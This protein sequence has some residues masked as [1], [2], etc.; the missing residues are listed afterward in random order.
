MESLDIL[1]ENK[2]NGFDKV[3]WQAPTNIAFVKYWGKRDNQLPQNPSI[4]LT[5]ENSFTDT[6]IYYRKSDHTLGSNVSFYFDGKKNLHFEE[7][8]RKYLNSIKEF[9]PFISDY[10]LVISSYNTFPHSA[11]IASSASSMAS[12]ALCLTAMEKKL[13]DELFYINDFYKK[14]SY[15]ARLGSGSASRSIYGSFTV[16]GQHKDIVDS[17]DDYAVSIG[18]DYHESF[19]YLHDSIL[20]VN[21]KHKKV[22]SS[23]GHSLMNAHPFAEKRYTLANENLSK[24]YYAIKEGNIDL[25]IGIIESEALTLHSLM[26]TSN[27]GYI[28]IEPNTIKIINKIREIRN[29]LKLP[30][31]FTL[32]AGPNVHLIYQNKYKSEVHDIIKNE[33]MQYCMHHKWIDDYMGN[34]P[35]EIF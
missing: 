23:L 34:G 25:F 24:I 31:G 35:K 10:E 16:W 22:S 5:L 8:I 28:L 2:L 15:I 27:P 9:F 7:R 32:D 30:I 18:N 33:L 1:N 3:R 26:M 20:I 4:S 21:N 12:I 14:A 6:T 17:S 29:D 19:K 13:C 11:G